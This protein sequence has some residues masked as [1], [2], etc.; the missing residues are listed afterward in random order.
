[1]PSASRV[2][3]SIRLSIRLDLLGQ[4]GRALLFVLRLVAERGRERFIRR[5][6]LLEDS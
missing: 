6:N 4:A 1:M 5:Q 3:L 2:A